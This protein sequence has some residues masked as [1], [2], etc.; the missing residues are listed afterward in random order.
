LAGLG[1]KSAGHALDIHANNGRRSS[2]LIA[3]NIT[4]WN[5][6]S[7]ELPGLPKGHSMDRDGLIWLA[8]ADQEPEKVLGKQSASFRKGV[9]KEKVSV[10]DIDMLAAMDA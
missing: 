7:P 1:T 2:G 8:F 6:T 5:F 3:G 4:N 9:K 10:N